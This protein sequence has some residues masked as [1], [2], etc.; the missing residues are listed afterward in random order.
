M[1]KEKRFLDEFRES[2]KVFCSTA[3]YLKIPD[4]PIFKGMKTRFN[5]ERPFDVIMIWKGKTFTIEAKWHDRLN[6][7]KTKFAPWSFDKVASHQIENLLEAKQNGAY[8]YILVNIRY[9]KQIPKTNFVACIEIDEFLK[10]KKNY[11]RKSIEWWVLRDQ[12]LCLQRVKV[13][14][15]KGKYWNINELV[16]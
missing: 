14:G 9:T 15:V 4:P 16:D 1:R 3:F 12:F 7:T 2:K 5:V 10:L 13:E 6:K 8:A 11:G